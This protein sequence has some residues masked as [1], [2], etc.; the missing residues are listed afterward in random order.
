M[1]ILQRKSEAAAELAPQPPSRPAVGPRPEPT[2]A[3]AE[4]PPGQAGV[5]PEPPSLAAELRSSALLF[6]M[7]LFA[8]A[9]VAGAAQALVHVLTR[10]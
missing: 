4:A 10:A 2:G 1:Q 7:A 6:G 8:T 9:G 5:V 3:A